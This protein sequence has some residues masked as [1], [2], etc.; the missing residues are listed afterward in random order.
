MPVRNVIFDLGG[1]LLDWNPDGILATCYPDAACRQLVKEA[2]FR[3]Q[4]WR[5]FDRGILSEPELLSRVHART[6]RSLVELTRVLDTVRDS[7]HEKSETVAILRSLHA[8]G[9]PL[10]C[11]SNM[12][13]SVF[14]Y[15]RQRHGFWDAFKGIVVSGIVRMSKPE[16]AVFEHLLSSYGIA[17][18]ETVFVD[19]HP[20]N[21]EGALALGM[22][23]VLFCDAQ[24]CQRELDA[25]FGI[26]TL[27]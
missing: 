9:V 27:I 5:D 16:R 18:E 7:L 6:G 20:P 1:V 13:V 12:P 11:L 17:A 15:V 22:R 21:I 10:Y 4:D 2:L 23:T 26:D 24:Q 8:R 14:E 3:H 25:Y 19:D